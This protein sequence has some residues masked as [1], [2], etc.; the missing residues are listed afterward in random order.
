MKLRV[1]I[2]RNPQIKTLKINN[3]D[4]DIDIEIIITHCPRFVELIENN[5]V[6][7]DNV[8]PTLF[9]HFLNSSTTK[10][11]KLIVSEF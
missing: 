5:E 4:V 7:L 2:P 1:P 9:Q 10:K 6:F 11:L 8:T 3:V